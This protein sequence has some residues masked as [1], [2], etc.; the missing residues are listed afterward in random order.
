MFASDAPS[1]PLQS[2]CSAAPVTS[3]RHRVQVCT[4]R[5]R[6][7]TGLRLDGVSTSGW[8]REA[9]LCWHLVRKSSSASATHHPQQLYEEPD[10]S[11]N[12]GADTA[13]ANRPPRA[14][15]PSINGELRVLRRRRGG[16][17]RG[18]RRVVH[19]LSTPWG[20]AA[21]A[22]GSRG[23]HAALRGGGGARVGLQGLC[24][25]GCVAA[26]WASLRASAHAHDP[27]V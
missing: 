18:P 7:V 21:R 23:A 25:G 26:R 22:M 17:L 10:S 3:T 8:I 15:W 13:R 20:R 24:V 9:D 11:Q 4:H 12:R 6:S 16:M 14:L 5:A 1:T 2:H 27:F 19:H